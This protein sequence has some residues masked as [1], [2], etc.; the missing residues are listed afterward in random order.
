MNDIIC[1][2]CSLLYF[3]SYVL[4]YFVRYILFIVYLQN[5]FLFV[6]IYPRKD[7]VKITIWLINP[8]QANVPFL[9]PE[10]VRKPLVF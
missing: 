7:Q 9:Y 5:L 3:V 1:S 6:R 10:N 4:L 8:F 2:C